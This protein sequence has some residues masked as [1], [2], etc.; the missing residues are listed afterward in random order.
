MTSFQPADRDFVE[1]RKKMVREDLARR[2]I[3]DSQI[4]AAFR[5]VPREQFVPAENWR[6]AYADRAL[7]IGGGQTI[8]QPYIVALMTQL[9]EPEKGM[10]VLEIGTGSGYQSAILAQMEAHVHTIEKKS[11]LA[12]TARA[13]L[14]N[15]NLGKN[16]DIHVGDG[17]EGWSDAAP[18][19]RIL[20]TA[21]SPAVPPPLKRQLV[22]GGRL[23][24]P[25]GGRQSQQLK[26]VTKT[27]PGEFQTRSSISCVFVPLVGKHGWDS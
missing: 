10:K 25:V 20:V 24:I 16:V 12:K 23:V 18:Y 22:S 6:V 8:S 19:E 3:H 1:K 2:D 15:V 27:A 21:A 14:D 9:L 26:V 11:S 4:L 7:P 13:N 5:K 17:T